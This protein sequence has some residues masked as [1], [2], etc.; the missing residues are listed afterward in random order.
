MAFSST[1]PALQIDPEG[2]RRLLEPMLPRRLRACLAQDLRVDSACSELA[3]EITTLAPDAEVLVSAWIAARTS[4][5]GALWRDR[6]W[7]ARRSALIRF[8]DVLAVERDQPV[9][10]ALADVATLLSCAG[11]DRRAAARLIQP[12]WLEREAVLGLRK[13]FAALAEAQTRLALGRVAEP[14]AD[15]DVTGATD[16][17]VA[18]QAAWHDALTDALLTLSEKTSSA[19][20]AAAALACGVDDAF[21]GDVTLVHVLV[22]F[23]ETLTRPVADSAATRE[24]RRWKKIEAQLVQNEARRREKA[25]TVETTAQMPDADAPRAEVPKGHVLVV[26]AIQETGSDRGKSIAR[27]YEHIIGKP[28]PLVAVPDLAAARARLVFEFPYASAMIDRLLAD[29]I[30]REHATF[31]PTLLIGPPGAGKSRIVARIAHHLGLGLW[32]VDATRDAGASLGGLDR[33]WA[34]SEPAHPI[35]AVARSG[36]ANPLMLIDELEKAATRA[37][38]GRLWDAL[39]PMLEPETARAYQDPCFQTETDISR[40]SWLGTANEV[41]NL[42]APL[43]DRLRVLEMPAPRHADLEALLGPIVARIAEDRGL[44]S[45]FVAPLDGEAITLL[46]RSWRGGSVR[47]LMRLVEAFVTAREALAVRQ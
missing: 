12:L 14:G 1:P 18:L 44:T 4:S 25:A 9:A 32:R 6:R 42:P 3:L 34:T 45:A 16:L 23:G 7:I 10:R 22:P 17:A 35:M 47:R 38:H 5:D 41:G 40:V 37:D 39:L 24:R 30:G 36:T 11:D 31:R 29:L 43:L 8:L 21:A 13:G 2:A 20:A 15:T 46:R 28:L 19:I 26:S 33:R 27:G